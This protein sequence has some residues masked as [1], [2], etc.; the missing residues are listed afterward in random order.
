[1]AEPRNAATVAALA[2]I[3]TPAVDGE[4]K[5]LSVVDGV[6]SWVSASTVAA[7]VASGVSGALST[8]LYLGNDLYV[9]TTAGAPVDYT[10][11][12]PPATGEGVYGKGSLVVR[13]DTGV[14]HRNSGTK[15]QPA[16]TA[17]DDA[18]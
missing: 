5:Y 12:S 17:F 7:A 3:P 2:S 9:A 6:V 1:M 8:P 11:G 16:W 18:D 14:W 13:L 10:D 15:A 4:A